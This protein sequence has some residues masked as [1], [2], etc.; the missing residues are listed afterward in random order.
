L[1]VNF[2]TAARGSEVTAEA[3]VLR[4]GKNLC[5]ID[6]DVTDTDGTLVAKGIV[7]YKLG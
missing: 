4:R 3:R 1:S 5:F 2:V 6:V 7:T